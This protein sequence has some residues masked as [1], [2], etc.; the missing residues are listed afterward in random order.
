VTLTDRQKANTK[1]EDPTGLLN[2]GFRY[3]DLETGVFITRDPIGNQLMMPKEKWFVDGKSVSEREYQSALMPGVAQAGNGP[4]KTAKDSGAEADYHVAS[5]EGGAGP[6]GHMHTAAA[7]FPNLYTYVNENP[8]TF[9]DPEGLL[10][11]T[12]EEEGYKAATAAAKLTQISS[13]VPASL[14]ESMRT[15]TEFSGFIYK[16]ADGQFASTPPHGGT[17]IETT[18]AQGRKSWRG[19]GDLGDSRSSVPKDATLVAN[20]HSHTTSNVTPSNDPPPAQS[21]ASTANNPRNGGHMYI[22]G[23]DG[24]N[25]RPVVNKVTP[26]GN[27]TVKTEIMKNPAPSKPAPPPPPPPAN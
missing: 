2:E 13:G 10:S 18:D 4:T 16:R 14:P 5:S 22:G 26:T 23:Q 24:L 8:W 12:E 1:E 27:G 25:G 6:Q 19:S 3:R 20:Y 21:D 15:K 9:F 17:P 11:N 7:G